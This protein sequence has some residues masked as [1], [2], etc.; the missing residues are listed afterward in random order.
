MYFNKKCVYNLFE[1]IIC[2]DN[3]SVDFKKY[4]E[5]MIFSKKYS[6]LFTKKK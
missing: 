3:D 4:R 1:N 5:N 6:C 2:I